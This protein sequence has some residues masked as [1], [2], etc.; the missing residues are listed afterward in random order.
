MRSVDP[1][2]VTEQMP[3]VMPLLRAHWEEVARNKAVMVLDP[4]VETYKALEDRGLLIALGA[5][6]G[7][8]LVGYSVTM[9][10]AKHLHYAGLCYAQNDVIFVDQAHRGAS[11]LGLQLILETERIAKERG[12]RLIFWHAKPD[13]PFDTLL[14]RLGYAVQDIIH[15]REL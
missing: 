2:S 8:V 10:V 14:P 11:R 6:D 13:T 7:E 3:L 4:D 9:L 5:F 12:A 1:I 15:S